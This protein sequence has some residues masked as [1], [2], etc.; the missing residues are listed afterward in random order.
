MQETARSSEIPSL[1]TFSLG[2]AQYAVV[3][4]PLH[5]PHTMERLTSAEREVA[6]LAAAGLSNA[7][8]ARERGTAARTVANQM[9][10]LLRKLG[11]GARYLLAARLAPSCGGSP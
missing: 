7:A 10:S 11:V 8:I 1:V 9:A 4:V 6:S 5:D 3:S 2:G